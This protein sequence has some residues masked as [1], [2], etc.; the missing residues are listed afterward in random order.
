MGTISEMFLMRTAWDT[1]YVKSVIQVQLNTLKHILDN[2]L[3]CCIDSQLQ[4]SYVCRKRGTY[5]IPF[6]SSQRKKSQGVKSA[7]R[8]LN[9]VSFQQ[10]TVFNT[11]TPDPSSSHIVLEISTHRELLVRWSPVLLENKVFMFMCNELIDLLTSSEAFPDKHRLLHFPQRKMGHIIKTILGDDAKHIHFWWVPLVFNRGVW[12]SSSQMRTLCLLTF[13]FVWNVVSSLKTRRSKN[14]SSSSFSCISTQNCDYLYG[15]NKLQLVG[16]HLQEFP[17]DAPNCRWRNLCFQSCSSYGLFW[18]LLK[19]L[20]RTCSTF[21]SDAC[22]C[23]DPLIDDFLEDS[24]TIANSNTQNA[25]ALL[26]NGIFIPV[27]KKIKEHKNRNK[28]T[29]RK[30]NIKL[31]ILLK[32]EGDLTKLLDCEMISIFLKYPVLYQGA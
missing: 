18:G 7:E 24:V 22:G 15:L 13:P 1:A 17:Q 16:F 27:K 6:T 2:S 4:F 9:Q 28:K 30:A 3:L 23:P 8:G 32:F 20:L 10:H 25:F 12:F 26:V 11:R 21:S 19:N 14:L 29:K 5:T 31:K